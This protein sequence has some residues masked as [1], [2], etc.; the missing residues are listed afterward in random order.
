M[1]LESEQQY[2]AKTPK[3]N[4]NGLFL[5]MSKNIS[6]NLLDRL[7]ASSV[8]RIV[9][10]N[11]A[12]H[13]QKAAI[14]C[15]GCTLSYK[16]LADRIEAIAA[17]LDIQ[18]AGPNDLVGVLISRNLDLVPALLGVNLSGAGYVP[19]DPFFPANR[20]EYIIADSGLKHLIHDGQPIIPDIG[21]GSKRVDL[22]E[23]QPAKFTGVEP[24]DSQSLAYSIYTSGSTGKP[25][26]VLIHRDAL[27]N[28]LA[29]MAKK[30]GLSH[31]D[32]LL[33]VTT[34]SF[35]IAV[36]ELFLTLLVGGTVFLATDVERR[37]GAAIRQILDSQPITI[38]QATPATWQMLLDSEWR[39]SPALRALSGGEALSTY[40][41]E[42]LLSR[43][44]ELWNMYGPTETTI[45]SSC[46]KI[47]KV[48][49][50]SISV[51]EPIDNT[52]FRILD[53][54]MNA[55]SEGTL[56]ELFIGGKGLALGYSSS[57]LTARQFLPD[58][59]YPASS[60]QRLYRTGDSAF[61]RKGELYIEGRMDTQI[62]VRGYRVEPSEIETTLE[63]LDAIRQSVVL[64]I[65]RSDGRAV[66][67]AAVRMMNGF[68]F[69]SQTLALTLRKVLP[70][71]MVP[72]QFVC[73]TEFPK[74]PNEKIDR[75]QLSTMLSE[76]FTI[77]HVEL[78]KASTPKEMV[79]FLIKE[80]IGSDNIDSHTS[81]FDQGLTSLQ[82]NWV[83]GELSRLTGQH[84]S[85]S[86]LFENPTLS[87]FTRVIESATEHAI[88]TRPEEQRTQ[89]RISIN[90]GI[91]IIAMAGRFPGADTL[92]ELWH[93]LVEGKEGI[94]AFTPEQDDPIAKKLWGDDP[95]Y[96][97]V[98]GMIRNPEMF[99]AGLFGINPNDAKAMDPQQRV[100]LELAWEAFEGA[101]YL[102]GHENLRIGSFAGMGNNFYYHYNVSTHPDHI[103]MIGGVQTEIGREK[104]HIATLV[105]YKLNLKGPS[106]SIHT[107]C[108]TS[109]VAIDSACQALWSGQC[110][111]AVAGGIELRT[112]QFSGQVHEP[113]SIFTEDGHC[114]PFSKDA[115]GTMFSD[116]AGVLILKRLTQA[117]ADGDTILAVIRGSATNH[118]G[119]EKQSYLAPSVSGQIDVIETALNRGG[120]QA[121]TISYIEAH[122]TGTLVGDPIEFE[123]LRRV[124][125]RAGAGFQKCAIGSVKANL[126]H[127][128]T[129][130]GVVGVI[131]TILAMQHQIIP[132]LA[133]FNGINPNIDIENSPFFI[134]RKALEWEVNNHPR[135]AGVS[136]FGFCGT[137]SHIVLEE[138]I[139]KPVNSIEPRDNVTV[140]I[141]ISAQ[142]DEALKLL[143][144]NI[145][146]HLVKTPEK[147]EESAYTLAVGRRRLANS[148]ILT[149][150]RQDSQ[151]TFTKP[152]RVSC[153]PASGFVKFQG[154]VGFL[155]PGQGAQYV[156]M[157]Q[158]LY[159]HEPAFR[160]A[161]DE[162][163]SLM[164]EEMGEDLSEVMF[165]KVSLPKDVPPLINNTYY[166]QPSIFCLEYALARLWQSWGIEPDFVIGHSIGEFV[167][168]TIAGVFELSEGVKAIAARGRLVH[169]LPT[170]SML[171]VRLSEAE[172]TPLIPETISLAAVNSAKLCVVAG[173]DKDIRIFAQALDKQGVHQKLL[174]TSH[175]FHSFMMDP[176]IAPFRQV[177]DGLALK[178][179]SI[180]IIS[181]VTGQKMTDE[182]ARDLDY[183]AE[184]LRKPVRFASAVTRVLA[185]CDPTLMIEVG[186]RTTLSSLSA[187]MLADRLTQVAVPSLQGPESDLDESQ[188]IVAAYGRVLSECPYIADYGFFEESHRRRIPM[189]TYPFQRKSYWLEPA[190][191]PGG[192]AVAP[193]TQ[194]TEEATASKADDPLDIVHII[195]KLETVLTE[196]SGIDLTGMNPSSSFFELG[197]DS[198][199]LTPLT[200]KVRKSFGIRVTFRQLLRDI[201]TPEALAQHIAI[202]LKDK[203]KL[204]TPEIGK[205]TD[206]L[207]LPTT[208]PVEMPLST[209]QILHTTAD[210][211]GEYSAVLAFGRQLDIP[212]L[213]TCLE[214]MLKNHD[215][216]RVRVNF[217]S[218]NQSFSPEWQ[219]D[220]RILKGQTNPPERKAPAPA[221]RTDTNTPV[222]QAVYQED[223]L[224][225]S[226]LRLTLPSYLCDIWSMDLLIE[227]L[228]KLYRDH[229]K[230]RG[231]QSRDSFA[232][233]VQSDV[234]EQTSATVSPYWERQIDQYS[235]RFILA[236]TALSGTANSAGC[237]IDHHDLQALRGLA[238][239]RKQ[240]LI[241]VLMHRCAEVIHRHSP[242]AARLFAVTMSGQSF[243]NV[244][245]LVG[246][247]ANIT[248]VVFDPATTSAMDIHE[249]LTSAYENQQ[250]STMFWQRYPPASIGSSLIRVTH[251]KRLSPQQTDFGIPFEDYWFDLAQDGQ[252]AQ[253]IILTED[254]DKLKVDFCSFDGAF[255][256]TLLK[257][258]VDSIA[259]NQTKLKISLDTGL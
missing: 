22:T 87:G 91:A 189:P 222:L 256:G 257:K 186:P 10:E 211:G 113:G 208:I 102:A 106:L 168:A 240:S 111:M 27:H 80:A 99:D 35:D 235:T 193:P 142:N 90:D 17:E 199:L 231:S 159:K 81:L 94:T 88:A 114:R 133:N 170:G 127:P 228:A 255:S 30:P 32:M 253:Q 185:D 109:L 110:E 217:A 154:N 156:G 101:G 49:A 144:S 136:S 143:Q 167:G 250:A 86:M 71:Y 226:W 171:S 13:P 146:D 12:A 174:H 79:R 5:I 70:D 61:I 59:F 117:E 150:R 14:I 236:S 230:A 132:P 28:F 164:S 24:V 100:F 191:L 18:R 203:A 97:R 163:V 38:M 188:S 55:V 179:P 89:H 33:A 135:R 115:S 244:P 58:P 128:T 25:K 187:Q 229:A 160:E 73:L 75:R 65:K 243:A 206:V 242:D 196:I 137:N 201:S 198:L 161:F 216:L 60:G 238:T 121:D 67:C 239:K 3:F 23:I 190:W 249:T 166:T 221:R 205:E 112:P 120:I 47:Q 151:I 93:M 11:A 182:T 214:S 224:G 129:A 145:T 16:N 213:E 180:P 169:D 202:G 158:N 134:P 8:A 7:N 173:R 21:T 72:E 225:Q 175:A 78:T 138:Y 233:I 258:I 42:Q 53:Q 4:L 62:K 227:K 85:V 172:L 26:G 148:A 195:G 45:W 40:L 126:G 149:A 56:G 183:W 194:T 184:H 92:E 2:F 15:D 76:Q 48:E 192:Q 153:S 219:L 31:T 107:A 237:V 245:Q 162:C 247:C 178:I 82:A 84:Y 39:G 29:S 95:G 141:I 124:F 36:L 181:S 116:G 64:Q 223:G 152:T 165:G 66:L 98:R 69:E 197:L 103:A 218:G 252:F 254:Q 123:A 215:A 105:S 131:K 46:K 68:P 74:T 9:L 259:V 220:L 43:C 155:F 207:S 241:S 118:D 210:N 248:P 119:L 19:L 246:Q 34:P 104:D 177:L 122:G 157:G 54:E 176:V 147:L 125:E 139:A 130:A 140:P 63:G 52:Y 20:L 234:F 232:E 6:N 1:R 83:S 37:D 209:R 204:T 96:R 50:G 41:A 44:Y 51:G 200:F 212:R 77:S 251:I 57:E 108:S